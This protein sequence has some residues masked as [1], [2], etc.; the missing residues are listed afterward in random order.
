[1]NI[2]AVTLIVG[3][4]G[5]CG[6]LLLNNIWSHDVQPSI[7]EQCESIGGSYIPA[8]PHAH[9]SNPSCLLQ[10]PLTSSIL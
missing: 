3:V 2:A 10:A 7:Q 6:A 9:M 4:L 5:S 8:D 1:M